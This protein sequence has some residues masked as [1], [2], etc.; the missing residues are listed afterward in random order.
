MRARLPTRDE[1]TSPVC[2]ARYA[3][4]SGL[5]CVLQCR[6][7]LVV[8]ILVRVHHSPVSLMGDEP[9]RLSRSRPLAKSTTKPCDW[10]LSVHC[11]CISQVLRLN[12]A[13]V[14][15]NTGLRQL[16]PFLTSKS[17][18]SGFNALF[19]GV[20][21]SGVDASGVDARYIDSN[22]VLKA[23]SVRGS[24]SCCIAAA[25]GAQSH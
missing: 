14:S 4:F 8:G 2:V 15:P 19:S 1:G 16:H 22:L 11:N 24:A 25:S 7:L 3:C 21:A 18:T 17:C 20:D 23:Y 6:M 13:G 12:V 5:T 10:L 9:Q